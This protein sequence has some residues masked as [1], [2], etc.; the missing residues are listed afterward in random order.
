MYVHNTLDLISVIFHKTPIDVTAAFIE[1]TAVKNVVISGIK[2]NVN[3]SGQTFL[4]SS[5]LKSKNLSS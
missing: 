3:L 4:R 5:V 1:A 2:N